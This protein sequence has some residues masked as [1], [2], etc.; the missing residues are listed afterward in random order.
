MLSPCC[1]DAP[2]AGP[3]RA[4]SLSD[5][6][7]DV[8]TKGSTRPTLHCAQVPGLFYWAHAFFVPYRTI[9][10]EQGAKPQGINQHVILYLH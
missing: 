5:S 7:W 2:G 8:F 4:G 10:L 9:P 1:R 6:R 3:V